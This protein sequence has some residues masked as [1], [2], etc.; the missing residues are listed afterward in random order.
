MV[1]KQKY[2]LM[3]NN[4]IQIISNLFLIDKLLFKVISIQLFHLKLLASLAIKSIKLNFIQVIFLNTHDA[5]NFK[6]QPLLASIRHAPD[7]F[8]ENSSMKFQK[9]FWKSFPV[10]ANKGS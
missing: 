5:T 3:L 4:Q 10:F 9:K 7:R 1:F 8:L 6:S 2:N